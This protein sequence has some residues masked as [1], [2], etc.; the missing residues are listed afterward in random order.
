MDYFRNIQKIPMNYTN[1]FLEK[2]FE[3]NNL[4]DKARTIN[5]DIEDYLIKY[6]NYNEKGKKFVENIYKI[7]DIK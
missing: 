1:D 6:K 7:N 4:I 3:I 2:K 5:I